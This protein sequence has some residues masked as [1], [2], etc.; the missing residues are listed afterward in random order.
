MRCLR[1]ERALGMSDTLSQMRREDASRGHSSGH[2]FAAFARSSQ[3]KP[4][5]RF[6]K[7]T[8]G[9]KEALLLLL[10]RLVVLVDETPDFMGDRLRYNSA[11]MEG[12]NLGKTAPAVPGAGGRET[13]CVV[14]Q[15]DS[16]LSLLPDYL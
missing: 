16:V 15:T 7:F 6:K 3:P 1:A 11:Y 10:Q 14:F 2:F 4:Q 13:T 12:V 9:E 8:T 5:Q